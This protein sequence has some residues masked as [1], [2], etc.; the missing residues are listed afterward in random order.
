[1]IWCGGGELGPEYLGYIDPGGLNVSGDGAFRVGPGGLPALVVFG[2]GSIVMRSIITRILSCSIA[3]CE[4][5]LAARSDSIWLRSWAPSDRRLLTNV[6]TFFSMLS[7]VSFISLYQFFALWRPA[8][9]SRNSW[10]ARLYL[11]TTD[12]R[13][14]CIDSYLLCSARTRLSCKRLLKVTVN[15]RISAACLW[16]AWTRRF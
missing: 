11:P 6:S 8:N 16:L 13:C 5:L 3:A 12:P 9:R 2:G 1:M 7:T 10:Y 15:S 4:F 14:L